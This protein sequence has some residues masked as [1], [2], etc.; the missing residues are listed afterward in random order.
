MGRL[1]GVGR[2]CC[3]G[4]DGSVSFRFGVFLVWLGRVWSWEGVSW[5]GIDMVA[6]SECG[7]EGL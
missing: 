5:V 3:M 2:G 1:V 7:L 6:F 4:G